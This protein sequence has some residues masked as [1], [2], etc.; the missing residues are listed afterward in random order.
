MCRRAGLE[1][2]TV[3]GTRAGEAWY[4]N[5]IQDNGKYFHV[6]L[7]RCSETGSFEKKPDSRMSGYVWDYSAYPQCIRSAEEE[8]AETESEN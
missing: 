4:W 3:T 1:G 7:L 6:D 2:S 8:P 5:I